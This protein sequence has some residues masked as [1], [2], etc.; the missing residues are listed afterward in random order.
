MTKDFVIL[1]G[2]ADGV[3]AAR[4]RRLRL[5]RR[6]TGFG[7]IILMT[8]ALGIGAPTAIF[9]VVSAVLL[10]SL[11]YPDA[12][13][14]AA[15]PR[16]TVL[17]L[18]D[19]PFRRDT[20]ALFGAFFFCLMDIYI[21]LLLIPARLADAGFAP[22]VG[23]NANAAFTLAGVAGA[24]LGSG[25][26]E[27]PDR[28]GQHGFGEGPSGGSLVQPRQSRHRVLFFDVRHCVSIGT[29]G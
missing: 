4:A 3:D 1:R 15:R 13:S 28:Y 10:R 26:A 27:R 17:Q 23:T 19:P 6:R 14:H 24:I 11:P 2:H 22:M 12:E 29:F 21:G 5:L 9:S 25:S 7:G 8:I 18:F 20:F 16:A